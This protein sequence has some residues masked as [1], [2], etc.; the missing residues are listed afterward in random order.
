MIL[1]QEDID[2]VFEENASTP[3][4]L[5]ESDLLQGLFMMTGDMKYAIQEYN[6]LMELD[7]E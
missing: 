3:D 7:N 1:T 6:R 4:P 2:A 5:T